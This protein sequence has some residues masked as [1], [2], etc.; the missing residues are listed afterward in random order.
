M[1][2]DYV[3]IVRVTD[4][5]NGKST[6]MQVWQRKRFQDLMVR[7]K[8]LYAWWDEI[9][10]EWSTDEVD[11]IQDLELQLFDRRLQ[12]DDIVQ[13]VSNVNGKGYKDFRGYLYWVEDDWRQIDRVLKFANDKVTKDDYTTKTLSYP[14]QAGDISAWDRLVGTLYAPEEREK[15]EWAIGSIIAGESVRLQ[16]FFVFYGAP[17]TGKSTILRIIER[18][19][20]HHVIGFDSR[21]LA[22]TSS[23]FALA[24]FAKDPLVAL[25]H[26]GDLSRI[27]SNSGLNMIVAHEP[28]LINE[29]YKSAY[30]LNPRSLLFI[31][32]NRPVQI[33]ESLSGLLRRMIEISPSN[34][35]LEKSEYMDV[36]ERINFEL[37]HIA[38]HCREVY[39][40]LGFDYYD[41]YRPTEMLSATNDVYNFVSEYEEIFL[42]EEFV[43]LKRLWRLYKEWAEETHTKY[44]H[45]RDLRTELKPYFRKFHEK[46]KME[47]DGIMTTSVFEGFLGLGAIERV[48]AGAQYR[49]SLTTRESLLDSLLSHQ[50][51]QYANEEGHPKQAW[52]NVTTKLKDIDTTELHY[53]MVPSNHIVID[54]DLRDEN[55][56][57][58]LAKNIAAAE[59]WPP[60]YTEV[61]KSGHGVH[62]HYKYDGDVEELD[63]IYAEGIE[64]KTFR[65]KSSL[66]RKLSLC[67]H[68]PLYTI[69][70]GLPKRTRKRTVLDEK[71]IKSEKALRELIERNLRKE[72]HASTKSSIDFI[73]KI[74]EDAVASGMSYDVR[75]MRTK[76][77]AFAIN[78]SNQAEYCVAKVKKMQLFSED[79][80]PQATETSEKPVT[81]FDIE[82]FPNL[83]LISYKMVGKGE[84]Q[85]LINPGPN[86][87]ENLIFN[88]RLVGFNNR[89]YDNHILYG[90]WLGMT[91][92]EIFR[93]S[94]NLVNSSDDAG[95]GFGEAYGLS[96]ADIFDFSSEKKG[97]KKWMFELGLPHMELPFPYDKPLPEE[98]WPQVVK[99]CENDVNATE[100]LWYARQ[101]DFAARQIMAELSGLTVN[102]TTRNHAIRIIFGSDMK[103]RN[104]ESYLR[105]TN[106]AEMF[107]GYDFDPFREQKSLYM[108]EE[109]GEG[110]Y[111][112][113]EPGIYHNV[114]HLDVASMHPTSIVQLNLFGDFTQRYWWLMQARLAIKHGDFAGVRTLFDNKLGQ[115][116]EDVE[117]NPEKAKQLSNA[118]KIVLNSV[119]GYTTAGFGNPFRDA[120]NKDNI[121]AKRGALFMITLKHAVQELGYKV[122]HIKTD[123][124]KIADADE[125]IIEFVMEFGRKYGYDF[126]LETLYEK[127]ALINHAD[128]VAY[129]GS[130]EAIGARFSHPY[131]Y[132][133]MFTGEEL[134]M[135]DFFELKA[136]Q[137]A[138]IYLDT[139]TEEG[140]DPSPET[141]M[142]LGRV[143]LVTPVRY[144]GGRLYRVGDDGKI[145]S[146]AGTQGY[147]WLPVDVVESNK[148]EYVT[149]MDYFERLTREAAEQII[150]VSNG[151][152]WHEFVPPEVMPF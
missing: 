98:Y 45:M 119:Y 110:G 32:T 135:R 63:P 100:A 128:Y 121:V 76:L 75:D 65:G 125:K 2:Q 85:T 112:Y 68:L 9:R 104:P 78:S 118:L 133:T 126:E 108:G 31:G 129:D 43:S 37:G 12:P 11:F 5:K 151:E 72:I 70:T 55:G 77:V 145:S 147:S 15:I 69:S 138:A 132:K 26:D 6:V 130:W 14:L 42:R 148:D 79:R 113:A 17:G 61:S 50:P 53:V 137:K 71:Q 47:P 51:A 94:S 88:C 144:G 64:V 102:D 28:V 54:F 38:W 92:E 87:V 141:M 44:G 74:L 56:E 59:H 91:N 19:F 82:V 109:V 10:E 40:R 107:P 89:K 149:D 4:P 7:G 36:M 111:V 131:V 101:P 95:R 16:K 41:R 142:F 114:A 117:E 99:Y 122:I 106:L 48:T 146:V 58:S 27:A 20:E 152:D 18:L 97:L 120:R 123:S 67:N 96:Y 49:L 127:I 62:L 46:H 22:S 140:L 116:L 8:R 30:E 35:I 13:S 134:T 39:Q 90:I 52:D 80:I 57:K 83:C 136:V 84:V 34:Q 21:Q 24:P 23:A 150:K 33:T 103:N 105:Y 66:R 143:A 60:T 115:F 3:N 93:L 73:E 1:A 29:K 81:I 139:V 86:D 124:I 25:E